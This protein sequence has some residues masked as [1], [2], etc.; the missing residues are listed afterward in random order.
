MQVY[1]AKDGRQQGPYTIE[2]INS[3]AAAGR[4]QPTDLAWMQGWSAWQPVSM[5]PG[6][7]SASPPPLPPAGAPPP[8]PPPPP[9]PGGQPLVGNL[10]Q[11]ELLRLFV[12]KNYEYYS[13]KWAEAEQKPSKNTWNWAAFFFNLLWTA[14]RK[15]YRYAWIVFGIAVAE[16]ICEYAFGLPGGISFAINIG[17]GI[18]YGLQ[19]NRW[20][21]VHTEQ[22]LRELLPAGAPDEAT[23]A[24][25]TRAGGTSTGAVAAFCAALFVVMFGIG[26]FAAIAKRGGGWE[27]PS[28][29]TASP[30]DRTMAAW[31]GL[32]KI[33]HDNLSAVQ[34]GKLDNIAKSEATIKAF[35]DIVFGYSQ[36]DIDGADQLLIDH[37]HHRIK[38]ISRA[39]DVLESRYAE[40][41]DA[42]KARDGDIQLSRK[43]GGVLGGDENREGGSDFAEWIYRLGTDEDFQNELQQINERHQPEI[44]A[45]SRELS[46]LDA[47][48]KAAAN[49]LTRKYGV[50]FI[51]S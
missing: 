25:I 39:A 10:Q 41:V 24:R 9:T 32:H 40:I 45:M 14:Y 48:E 44:E 33:D 1:I 38:T 28:P 51:I 11:Q 18:A 16:T 26:F 30:K 20:Y 7:L 42:M 19:G 34:G 17:V 37:L 8:L 31:K 47:E 5:V 43:V 12:G 50:E 4:I 49:E 6:F 35:R 15:M 36:L 3:E 27:S 2:Y 46:Q 21:K 23:R 13:R 22:K 29:T